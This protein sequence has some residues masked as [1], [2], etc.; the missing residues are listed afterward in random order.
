[1]A[2]ALPLDQTLPAGTL[3]SVPISFYDLILITRPKEGDIV[4]ACATL[5]NFAAT[6]FSY[7]T[8]SGI[9]LSEGGVLYGTIRPDDSGYDPVGN[10]VIQ[11]IK[12]AINNSFRSLVGINILELDAATVTSAPSLL[13]TL[14]SPSGIGDSITAAVKGLGSYVLIVLLILLIAVYFI[15]KSKSIKIG[16]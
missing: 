5:S 12:Q 10:D 16:I 7:N 2:Q 15:S 3:V 6:S 14:P 1:M 11:Q 4:A 9:G 13:S 8:L